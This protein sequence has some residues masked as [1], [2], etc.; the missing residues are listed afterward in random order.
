MNLIPRLC[1]LGTFPLAACSTPA[2]TAT[3]APTQVIAIPTAVPA[4]QLTGRIVYS[5]ENDIFVMDL[6][7]SQ[8]TRLT[9]DPEWDFDAAWSPDGTQ[10]VFRSCLPDRNPPS[11][12]SPF[13][14]ARAALS[15]ASCG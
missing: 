6:S 9:N 15:S 8:V 7:D 13:T 2:A 1:L 11:L 14:A 3:P 5:N 4:T 10:I 12:A